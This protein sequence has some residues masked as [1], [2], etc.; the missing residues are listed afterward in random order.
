MANSITIRNDNTK[1][2]RTVYVHQSVVDI[3]QAAKQRSQ[4]IKY[5]QAAYLVKHPAWGLFLCKQEGAGEVCYRIDTTTP[6]YNL[7][8]PITQV[9][10]D[11]FRYTGE[12]IVKPKKKE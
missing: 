10:T 12:P 9:M 4:A 3:A 7:D 6:R 2:Q 1:I 8:S 5:M 11:E